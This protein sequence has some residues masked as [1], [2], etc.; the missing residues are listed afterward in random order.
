MKQQNYEVGQVFEPNGKEIIYSKKISASDLLTMI[1]N[2]EEFDGFVV[3]LE[4]YPFVKYL[5]KTK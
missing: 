2:N 5:I 4:N 3:D 1:K